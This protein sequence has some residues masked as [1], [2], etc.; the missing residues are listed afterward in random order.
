[1]PTIDPFSAATRP[2]E[3]L[4]DTDMLGVATGFIWKQETS[5]QLFL[6]TNWHVVSG[7]NPFTRQHTSKSGHIP[8]SLRIHF[9]PKGRLGSRIA[10][11]ISLYDGNGPIWIIHP[12]HYELVDIVAIPLADDPQIDIWPINALS[13][14]P[15]AVRIGFDVFILGYSYGIGIDGFPIWKRGSIASEP[16]AAAYGQQFIFVDT[17]SRP[18]MSGSPIILRATNTAEM[19]DGSVNMFLG[20]ATRF[21]GVYSGRFASNDPLEAQLGMIW[22][23]ALY[24]ISVRRTHDEA[25]QRAA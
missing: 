16:T 24:Q 25:I 17:A 2:L 9:I 18:G 4:S 12:S 14:A 20:D 15:L 11:S 22:P 1:V 8:K 7:I 19:E 10:K 21:L 23:S 5:Q 13:T 3:L 6:I